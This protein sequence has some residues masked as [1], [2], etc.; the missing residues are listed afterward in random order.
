MR[1][2]RARRNERGVSVVETPIIVIVIALFS[3]GVVAFAQIMLSYQHLTGATRAAVRYAAK[4][5]YDPTKSPATSARRPSTADVSGFATSDAS[6]L[7]LASVGVTNTG[8][9]DNSAGNVGQSVNVSASADVNDGAYQLAS[10]LVNGLASLLPGGHQ[11][12][13]YPYRIHSEAVALYE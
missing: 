5:D 3:L 4:N 6:P 9:T 10:S 7:T 11:V 2:R 1:L 13:P 12:L 8:G